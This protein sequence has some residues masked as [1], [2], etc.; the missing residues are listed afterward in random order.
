MGIKLS[1][2]TR[3]ALAALVSAPSCAVKVEFASFGELLSFGALTDAARQ[4]RASW[5]GQYVIRLEDLSE[6]GREAG[7]LAAA[8]EYARRRASR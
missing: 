6:I 4:R 8:R 5:W 7:V 1:A 2:V 3:D